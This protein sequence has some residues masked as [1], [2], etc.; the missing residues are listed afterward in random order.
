M[1]RIGVSLLAVVVG[2]VSGGAPVYGAPSPEEI[3]AIVAFEAERPGT[4]I[5]RP[6][7]PGCHIRGGEHAT[8]V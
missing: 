5:N 8:K 3:A 1:R 7:A 4:P 2:G 6:V